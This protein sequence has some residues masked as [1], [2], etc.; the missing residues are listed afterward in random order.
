MQ[1]IINVDFDE[2]SNENEKYIYIIHFI[3]IPQIDENVIILRL[4][5]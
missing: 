2:N 4:G 5:R 1:L 3:G